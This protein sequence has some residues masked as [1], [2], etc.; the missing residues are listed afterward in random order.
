MKIVQ[1]HLEKTP[2]KLYGGTERVVENLCL[3]FVELGHE[4]TLISYRGEF[5]LP[6]VHHIYLD[7]LTPTEAST[8]VFSML[9]QADIYHFHLSLNQ[10]Q[11]QIPYVST[12]HGNLTGT[13]EDILKQSNLLPRKTIGI[14]RDHANRHGLS[15]FVYNGI[16]PNFIP[17][18]PTKA[19][20]N[21]E[22]YYSFLGRASLKRKG[23]PEAKKIAKALGKKLHIGGGR[24]ISFGNNKYFGHL[25][26]DEKYHLLGHSMALLFPIDWEEPFGLVMIESMFTGTPVF[27]YQ[28]GSVPEVLNQNNEGT[29]NII[30]PNRDHLLLMAQNYDFH[31]YAPET[32]RSY[33]TKYFSRNAMC[34][35]YLKKYKEVGLS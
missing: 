6:G 29:F 24:G 10:D 22:E 12:L 11:Y 20:H 13:V 28:R 9:P 34:E 25:N 19:R 8:K 23:L 2:V 21:S 15:N 3:G 35:N 7:H 1:I 32:I 4:V 16:N 27:G 33:A 31:K 5:Q 26:D 17:L 30:S 18:I 14:S